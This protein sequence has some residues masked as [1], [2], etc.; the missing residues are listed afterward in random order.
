MG[1][2]IVSNATLHNED[3]IIRKDVRIGDIIRIQ[4]AGMLFHK[5]CQWLR[6]KR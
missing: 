3:E 1:G 5:L 6:K 4:R 2:V